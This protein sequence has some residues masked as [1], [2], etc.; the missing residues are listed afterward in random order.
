MTTPAY[1][2]VTDEL[3]Y[4]IE[5]AASRR[6]ES[7]INQTI[8]N[9]TILR[10]TSELRALRAENA[11]LAKDAGRYRW[12]RDDALLLNVSAPAI[13]V[14]DESGH[15]VYRGNPWNSLLCSDDADSAIDAA[16]KEQTK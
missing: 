8:M 15:P 16:M 9:G 14:V 4:D 6:E 2:S 11:E 7:H 1:Q 10:L 3:L 12:L 13:M 5:A